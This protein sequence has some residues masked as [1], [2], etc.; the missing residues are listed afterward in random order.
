MTATKVGTANTTV[1]FIALDKW[2]AVHRLTWVAKV[3]T[4]INDWGD[5]IRVMDMGKEFALAK[6]QHYS[7]LNHYAENLNLVLA[8]TANENMLTGEISFID[9]KDAATETR[10]DK[11]LLEA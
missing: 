7:A 11:E 6:T 9:I 8:Q 4:K 1:Q 10:L 3:T 2:N 5:V